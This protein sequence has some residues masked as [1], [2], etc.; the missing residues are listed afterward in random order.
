MNQIT[1]KLDNKPGELY[2]ICDALGKRGINIT[3]M[4]ASAE[5]GSMKIVTSDETTTMKAF[6]NTGFKANLNELLVVRIPDRA[7]ELAKITAKIAHAGVNINSLSLITREKD[8]AVIGMEVD[9]LEK[10]K[11]VI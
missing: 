4:S 2:K 6:Q 10:A 3:A 1:V 8:I 11:N 5:G 9:N 7:G